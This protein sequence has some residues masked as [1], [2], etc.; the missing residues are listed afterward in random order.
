M[1]LGVVIGSPLNSHIHSSFLEFKNLGDKV[2]PLKFIVPGMK[3]GGGGQ[4]GFLRWGVGKFNST[5]AN[6]GL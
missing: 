4:I 2:L 3:V 5:H 1:M 6:E